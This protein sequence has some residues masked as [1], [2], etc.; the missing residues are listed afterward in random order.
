MFQ[1]E[2]EANRVEGGTSLK[3]ST[4]TLCTQNRALLEVESNQKSKSHEK[5]LLINKSVSIF[6]LCSDLSK[7]RLAFVIA[8]TW[9]RLSRK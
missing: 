4:C 6:T 1:I 5:A 9:H 3:T 7:F 8:S 2:E